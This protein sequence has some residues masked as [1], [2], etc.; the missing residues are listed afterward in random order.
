[1]RNL[2][3]LL[4]MTFGV[5]AFAQRNCGFEDYRTHL[6]ETYPSY[7]FN[8][9][10]IDKQIEAYIKSHPEGNNKSVITIPVVVHVVYRNSTQN[11]SGDQINSQI[12]VLNED[13][14]RT[15]PDT[16]STPVP[17]KPLA[18]D[19]QIQFCL[20]SRDPNGNWTNGVTRTQ[21]SVNSFSNDN[22]KYTST[23][24]KDAWPR[25]DYLN[26]WVCN[27]GGGLLGFATP[28]GAPA[29]VDGV[30]I[31]YNYFGSTNHDPG[32]PNSF[33]LHSIYKYGRTATHEVGHW[34]NLE[35]VWGSS[36]CG[37]DGVS[38]TPV[39]QGP[40]Y[41]CP[42]FPKI[43]CNNG[44]DGEMFMNY[45]DYSD[46]VCMNMFS[47][48]QATRMQAALSASRPTIL[49]SQG[50]NGAI[51]SLRELEVLDELSLYP[52]PAEDVVTIAVGAKY[53][54]TADLKLVD[55]SGRVVHTQVLSNS[56][57]FKVNVD[58]STYEA[59]VYFVVVQNH[60]NK[61]TSKLIVR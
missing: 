8:K 51:N 26:I 32:P 59:G 61:L 44:P 49:T 16:G 20:A 17:F 54:T 22:V 28:P 36:N 53:E 4:V 11:I 58:L 25:N 56:T 47:E 3:L 41:G 19:A 15:N 1:M 40:N 43:S 10:T 42:N 50:C 13:Y 2:A 9:E 57:N 21:T 31:G 5:A 48:G 39:Q 12:D 37:N 60:R 29:A 34:L 38:D 52:N 33:T 14:S 45:L 46:D 7:K 35:H 23:G 55:V 18:A 27:L 24:G 30:V 6:L